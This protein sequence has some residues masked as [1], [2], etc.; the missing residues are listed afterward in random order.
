MPK[1][2]AKT[3]SIFT[4]Y[5]VEPYGNWCYDPVTQTVNICM[6]T[7]D[8]HCY[9]V[10]LYNANPSGAGVGAV[11]SAE[12][13]FQGDSIRCAQLPPEIDMP[14]T[15]WVS[16]SDKTSGGS[17]YSASSDID[18]CPSTMLAGCA[19]CQQPVP[20]ALRLHLDS[21]V[22]PGS[23]TDHEFLNRVTQLLHSQDRNFPCCWFSLPLNGSKAGRNPAHWMLKKTADDSWV[24]CLRRVSHELATY[25]HKGKNSH[26]LPLKFK[27]SRV[28]KDFK[29]W[30]AT[31]TI[32][33]AE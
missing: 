15:I 24:L 2:A 19:H 10:Y 27:R 6:S 28:S 31:I 16:W 4:P 23:S 9:E 29:K 33:V 13:P 1:K 18:V 7:N 20:S 25:H 12:L 32:D 21:P 3:K 26:K 30:P 8:M 14:G 11:A 5:D 22:V 17:G